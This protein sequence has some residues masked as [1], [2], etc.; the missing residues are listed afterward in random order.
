[1]K[2]YLVM[3][4]LDGDE[5]DE[6]SEKR[7]EVI[8]IFA[9]EDAAKR[10]IVNMITLMEAYFMDDPNYFH[11]FESWDTEKGAKCSIDYA[12]CTIT[13]EY[14]IKEMLVIE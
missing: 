4:H 7:H 3:E 5:G 10:A 14:E 1:M 13:Y 11:G 8:G 6:S 12:C 9:T 2:V